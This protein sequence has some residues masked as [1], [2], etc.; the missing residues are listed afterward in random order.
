MQSSR[1]HD[2]RLVRMAD[3]PPIAC[4]LSQDGVHDRAQLVADLGRELLAID[5]EAGNA[6]LR[7]PAEQR[8]AVQAFVGAE[9]SCC[10]FFDFELT[11][12]P[13]GIVLRIAAP[14]GESGRF[15]DWSRGSSPAGA[16]SC[17]ER[18]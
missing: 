10:P 1:A 8:E 13:A 18:I 11:D 4:N 2:E 7:F 5:A 3:A 16:A 14:E 9:S 17:C 6:R 15:A 12:G